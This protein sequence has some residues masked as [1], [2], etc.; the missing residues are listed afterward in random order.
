MKHADKPPVPVEVETIT[1]NDLLD[2]EKIERIDFMSMDIEGAEPLALAGFD[3]E[4]F[5]PQLVCI[6]VHAGADT[7]PFIRTYFE[8][9]DYERMEEYVPYDFANWYYRPKGSH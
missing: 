6:E 4:R 3:I 2:R 5:A 8:E 1:L 7:E 9:H